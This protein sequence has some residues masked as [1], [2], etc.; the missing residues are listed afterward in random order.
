MTLLRL[1]RLSLSLV[2]AMCAGC[3]A[4]GRLPS[5]QASRSI[6]RQIRSVTIDAQAKVASGAD[7]QICSVFRLTDEQIRR[8]LTTADEVDVRS[9][10]ADLEYAPCSIEGTLTLTN[11]LAAKWEIEMSG[12]GRVVFDDD[13]ITLLHCAHCSGPFAR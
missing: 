9:Y 3:N 10:S 1:T 6:Y 7:P 2:L 8:F 11:G 4:A 13:H 12:R 5:D